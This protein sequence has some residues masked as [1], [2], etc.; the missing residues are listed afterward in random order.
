[1]AQSDDYT[2]LFD[3][4]WSL[5]NLVIVITLLMA[6]GNDNAAFEFD[7]FDWIST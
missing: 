5:D 7:I 3:G 1:M 2:V 4:I 6:Q